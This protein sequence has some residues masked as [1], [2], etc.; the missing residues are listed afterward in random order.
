M[1]INPVM[2]VLQLGGRDNRRVSTSVSSF[3]EDHYD[4]STVGHSVGTN[5]TN[6]NT[7][8]LVIA[9]TSNSNVAL[10][11]I[12]TF[13]LDTIISGNHTIGTAV[14]KTFLG[15]FADAASRDIV[16]DGW[17]GNRLVIIGGVPFVHLVDVPFVRPFVVGALLKYLFRIGLSCIRYIGCRACI[18]DNFGKFFFK[19]WAIACVI[20]LVLAA[21]GFLM[22]LLVLVALA[23][24]SRRS[25]WSWS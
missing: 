7:R 11:T 14:N 1:D 20:L 2:I 18:V 13:N 16:G 5:S 19:D 22:E 15:A 8:D 4:R 3:I 6:V 25:S 23:R 17:L 21:D 24:S 9:N 12:R 10:G